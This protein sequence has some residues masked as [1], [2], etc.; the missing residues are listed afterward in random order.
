MTGSLLKATV[1]C[2]RDNLL[3]SIRLVRQ[4]A[5][6]TVIGAPVCSGYAVEVFRPPEAPLW[7]GIQ[8]SVTQPTGSTEYVASSIR[9]VFASAQHGRVTSLILMGRAF[10][11]M[12][13]GGLIPFMGATRYSRGTV[14][15]L[16]SESLIAGP[17]GCCGSG[18]GSGSGAGVVSPDPAALTGL[19]RLMLQASAWTAYYGIKCGGAKVRVSSQRYLPYAKWLVGLRP[20]LFVPLGSDSA[21]LMSMDLFVRAVQGTVPQGKR[22]PMD[23]YVLGPYENGTAYDATFA[24]TGPLGI[25]FA[26]PPIPPTPVGDYSV[27]VTPPSDYLNAE[28]A[29][30]AYIQYLQG[31]PPKQF[32]NSLS[33]VS[34]THLGCYNDAPPTVAERPLPKRLAAADRALSPQRCALLAAAANLWYFGLQGSS[35]FGGNSTAPLEAYGAAPA[36]DCATMCAGDRTQRCGLVSATRQ[37]F[38][39]Y[40]VVR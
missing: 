18:P 10:A 11:L 34:W 15:A 2:T 23:L 39:L 6:D 9:F 24:I 3:S 38:S 4:L 25:F 30:G 35:C 22:P 20:D 29:A 36:A 19:E 32:D 16:G 37:L 8:V 27:G 7:A 13:A 14:L 21:Y 28:L 1:C 12:A 40:Q 17:T 33:A 31:Q 5:G 26:P